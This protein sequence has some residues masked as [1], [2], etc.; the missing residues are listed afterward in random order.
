MT[1]FGITTSFKFPKQEKESIAIL[2][3]LFVFIFNL[4]T[5]LQLKKALAP[6]LLTLLGIVTFV[7]FLHPLK[8]LS[9]ILLL[10]LQFLNWYNGRRH[11]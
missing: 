5:T 4:F 6:I 10:F 8:A 7:K 9:P 1:P 11:Y 3:K 2:L